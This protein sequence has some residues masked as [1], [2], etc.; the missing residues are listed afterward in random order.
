M[1]ASVF[2]WIMEKKSSNDLF[3][4]DISSAFIVQPITTHCKSQ[5]YKGLYIQ[6]KVMD[7]RI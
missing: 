3:I 7:I 1:T 4:S 5:T 2:P 6:T